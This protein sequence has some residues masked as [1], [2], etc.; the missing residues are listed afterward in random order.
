MVGFSI[1]ILLV[2]LGPIYKMFGVSYYLLAAFVVCAIL[3]W[4]AYVIYKKLYSIVECPQCQF[5]ITY[6]YLRQTGHC[7]KCG[8][9]LKLL[10]K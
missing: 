2:I 8:V 5:K 3:I 7:S 4:W 9:D 10:I 6:Q 1:L